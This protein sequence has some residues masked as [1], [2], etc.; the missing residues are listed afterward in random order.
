MIKRL[1][2]LTFLVSLWI[3][4]IALKT[5]V[6]GAVVTLFVVY[7]IV[8]LLFHYSPSLQ[9]HIVFLNFS[10]KKGSQDYEDWYIKSLSDHHPVI[11]YLHGNTSSRATAHRIEL[12]NVLRKMDYHVVA[13]DYRVQN[14]ASITARKMKENSGA[15]QGVSV[16]TVSRHLHELVYASHKRT[17]KP[18]LC[19]AD[20]SQV[21]P[22][23]PGVVHDAK[24]VYRFIRERCGSSPLFVWGHSLGT[25]HVLCFSVS[26]HAVRDLCLEGDSPTA[27]IFRKM[28]KFDWLFLKPLASSGIDF[29][30]EEHIT[31]VAAPVL[32]L[33]AE[34]DLVVPFTLGKKVCTL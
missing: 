16:G 2:Y 1:L 34:D 12:Y 6:V 11:L 23:E 33:H 22:N 21:Q 24:V 17:K 27:L 8:P 14:S 26:T 7:I 13:F 25:G 15:F 20:S 31:H 4:G 19:Y 29:R 3:G 18:L 9:R 5:V 28:P 30:S 32:I 10:P